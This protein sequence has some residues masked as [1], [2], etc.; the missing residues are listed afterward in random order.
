MNIRLCSI[1][2][3][4][5]SY[6]YHHNWR[7]FFS[8]DFS[9]FWIL[10]IFCSFL[11]GRSGRRTTSSVTLRCLSV[12]L[13]SRSLAA[14]RNHHPTSNIIGGFFYCNEFHYFKTI[15]TFQICKRRCEN[16]QR[17]ERSNKVTEIS[18]CVSLFW[19]SS[20]KRP[21]LIHKDTPHPD[22]IMKRVN[23]GNNNNSEET[24]SPYNLRRRNNVDWY[25]NVLICCV[26]RKIV[27][28]VASNTK[29]YCIHSFTSFSIAF[30]ES[31]DSDTAASVVDDFDSIITVSIWEI[32]TVCEYEWNENTHQRRRKLKKLYLLQFLICSM[33]CLLI[34]LFQIVLCISIAQMLCRLVFSYQTNKQ[35]Q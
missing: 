9:P 20:T 6:C 26:L 15:I 10:K 28:L 25:W 24:S 5:H 23:D 29:I 14:M 16:T 2:R 31:V 33:F 11:V 21:P 18:F 4:F 8:I 22:K 17:I 27:L 12:S 7:K 13:H 3:W 19:F 35:T 30:F 1:I 32:N 34:L